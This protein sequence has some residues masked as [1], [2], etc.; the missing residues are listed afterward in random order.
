MMMYLCWK[1][2]EMR[3]PICRLFANKRSMKERKMIPICKC[4]KLT[5]ACEYMSTVINPFTSPAEFIRRNIKQPII[6]VMRL[7]WFVLHHWFLCRGCT[8]ALRIMQ[9]KNQLHSLITN[10]SVLSVLS[11]LYI[12]AK[13]S[14]QFVPLR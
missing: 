5:S 11:K 1:V 6:W 4:N 9:M 14:K 2:L 12:H 7:Y 10:K 13:T 3:M 8:K